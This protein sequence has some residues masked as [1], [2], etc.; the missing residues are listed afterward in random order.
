MESNLIPVPNP[1]LPTNHLAW[2]ADVRTMS[3]ASVLPEDCN[4]QPVG[5]V[6]EG[7]QVN[8][9]QSTRIFTGS[10]YT[11]IL[12]IAFFF[13]SSRRKFMIA[14]DRRGKRWKG[15]GQRMREIAS[16]FD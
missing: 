5:I 2:T 1:M 14:K 3:Q 16:R 4:Y 10:C 13:S 11:Y 6:P 7:R 12:S 8:D 15:G 9:L